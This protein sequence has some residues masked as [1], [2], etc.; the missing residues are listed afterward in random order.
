MKKIVFF[1]AL[2]VIFAS[3]AF[4]QQKTF[5]DTLLDHLCGKW[6]LTGLIAG[7]S[8]THDIEAEWVLNHQFVLIR[9]VS[10]EKNAAG[11]PEYQAHVYVGWDEK[12]S[13]YICIWLDVWGG[14]SPETVGRGKRHFDKIP[15]DFKN[16]GGIASFHTTFA[17]DKVS[18][19]WFWMMDN[20]EAGVLK[21][22][23]RVSLTRK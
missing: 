12:T 23:A 13:E 14:F 17:Y 21:P 22:F 4:S 2:F 10:R 7:K 15:F 18:G 5:R 3:Q 11:E 16:A 8:T 6:V 19:M 20:D 1:F 9:E